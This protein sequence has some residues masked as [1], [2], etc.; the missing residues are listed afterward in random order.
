VGPVR[1]KTTT[2]EA[3]AKVMEAPWMEHKTKG[4]SETRTKC[5]EQSVLAP[6]TQFIFKGETLQRF[7]CDQFKGE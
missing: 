1:D 6:S 3:Y 5:Y 4:W 7:K 2:R